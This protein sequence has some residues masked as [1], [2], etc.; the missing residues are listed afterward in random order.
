MRYKPDAEKAFQSVANTYMRE[1]PWGSLVR[2]MHSTG[3]SMFF[4]VVYMHMFRGLILRF[5]SSPR[6]SSF[7]F[8]VAQFPFA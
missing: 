1:V 3:A 6:V 5:L 2:Y 7:G 4:I 8:L